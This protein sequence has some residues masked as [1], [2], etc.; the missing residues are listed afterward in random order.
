[1]SAPRTPGE[2]IRAAAQ[3]LDASRQA[4]RDVAEAV[5]ASRDATTAEP[6]QSTVESKP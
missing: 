3:R 5:K 1:M 2:A 4:T 6:A